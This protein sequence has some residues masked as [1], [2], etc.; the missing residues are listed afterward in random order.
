MIS[1]NIKKRIKQLQLYDTLGNQTMLD[2]EYIRIMVDQIPK[3]DLS[4][5]N[6]TYCDPQCGTGTIL[7]VLADILMDAL[8]DSIPDETDRLNHIFTKQLFGY[9]INKLQI[10]LAKSNFK[11]A[12]GNRDIILNIE[13]KNC[14]SLYKSFDYVLSNVDFDTITH[15][16]PK[17]RRQSKLCI[18]TGRANKNTYTRT[19]IF[20][21]TAYRSLTKTRTH[22]LLALMVFEPVKT[23]KKVKIMSD[24]GSFLVDNPPFLPDHD[25]KAYRYALE[26]LS[27]KLGGYRAYYGSYYR[28]QLSD[29]EGTVPLIF[30]VGE[31]DQEGFGDIIKVDESTITENEGVGR[32]KIVISKNGLHYHQSPVKY[33][34][35]EYGTGHNTI[36]VKIKNKK[37]FIEFY[38]Y[39]N[40]EAITTLVKALKATTPSNGT[41]FWKRI[42]KCE[43]YDIIKEIYDKH[44]K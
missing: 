18:I 25:I 5:P 23:H 35:P 36:W 42:P 1:N 2:E 44:Y 30:N 14:F 29:Q 38:K 40:S 9:D 16:V 22:T 34:G 28:T 41:T 8:I 32:H 15:F 19:N 7:L 20:Q 24:Q 3:N 39:Y 17:F 33:A 4:N 13:E 12:L 21:L 27:L 11:K 6:T 10:S 26:V 37:E 43:H 31:K